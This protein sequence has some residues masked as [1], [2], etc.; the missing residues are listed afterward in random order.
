LRHQLIRHILA[1]DMDIHIWGRGTNM[2]YKDPR[3]KGETENKPIMFAPY[4]FT[5]AIENAFY[6]WW[7]T[8]KFYDP[9]LVNTIPL[10]LGASHISDI[11][12]HN[13]HIQLPY[14]IGGIMDIIKN[15]Y[16]S[17][18]SL[19]K[20]PD[21]RDKLLTDLNYQHFIWEHFNGHQNRPK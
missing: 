15:V 11:F 17:G 3:V 20:L 4:R 5:I 2:V 9:I 1:S 7:I 6:P 12:G 14:D 21:M 16:H 18:A 10:Y 19:Y 13:S 8:E